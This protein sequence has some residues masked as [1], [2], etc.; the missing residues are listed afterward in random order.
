MTDS[1]ESLELPS[2][3]KSVPR[4][5]RKQELSRVC[6]AISKKNDGLPINTITK[7]HGYPRLALSISDS[8]INKQGNLGDSYSR[9]SERV[10]K[11]TPYFSP[12]FDKTTYDLNLR[13]VNVVHYLNEQDNAYVNERDTFPQKVNADRNMVQQHPAIFTDA[14]PET[15]IRTQST[16]F[17]TVKVT[18][19]NETFSVN[20]VPM[21]GNGNIGERDEYNNELFSD[22]KLSTASE[23]SMKIDTPTDMQ[24]NHLDLKRLIDPTYD[25]VMDNNQFWYW[26]QQKET[27]CQSIND[28]LSWGLI[29]FYPKPDVSPHQVRKHLTLT[30]VS[31]SRFFL[32]YNETWFIQ[33]ASSCIYLANG[34]DKALHGAVGPDALQFL[35]RSGFSIQVLDNQ[36]ERLFNPHQRQRPLLLFNQNKIEIPIQVISLF[37]SGN[38]LYLVLLT[39]T[40]SLFH[41]HYHVTLF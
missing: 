24:K 26:L 23:N 15:S 5:R 36:T 38:T 27:E 14:N 16:R 30:N 10:P 18:M 32:D 40:I 13:P 11:Q 37:V 35:Q 31:S 7:D 6:S 3:H 17:V 19:S 34:L 1:V 33:R 28:H 39:L 41:H 2:I 12:S 8:G 21:K 22:R 29:L 20:N 4:K 9:R 25:L